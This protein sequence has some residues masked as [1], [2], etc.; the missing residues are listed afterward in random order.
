MTSKNTVIV[1]IYHRHKLFGSKVVSYVQ[2]DGRRDLIG[3]MQG[4]EQA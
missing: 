1:L 2:M 4:C 3:S